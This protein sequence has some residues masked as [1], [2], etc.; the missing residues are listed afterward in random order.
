VV[1]QNSTTQAR[2]SL[3]GRQ[4]Q[5]GADD[6]ITMSFTFNTICNKKPFANH[7]PSFFLNM[8]Y[9]VGA[10]NSLPNGSS[11]LYGMFK[12]QIKIFP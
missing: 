6:I 1:A 10:T 3:E 2:W 12:L 8:F 4:W 5:K 7:S 11:A 9:F